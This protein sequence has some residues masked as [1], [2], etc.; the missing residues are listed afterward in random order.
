MNGLTLAVLSP[1]LSSIATIFYG[2]AVRLLNPFVALTFESFIGAIFIFLI[3]IARRQKIDFSKI[4]T[5][6]KDLILLILTRGIIGNLLITFG[7]T[8]STGIKAIF[9]TKAEPYF[10]IFWFWIFTREKIEKKHLFLLFIHILGAI[11]LSSGSLGFSFN[12]GQIGDFLIIAAVV[13][14]ALSYFPASKVVNHLG[15]LQTNAIT[16]F[17][18]GFVFLPFALLYYDPSGWSSHIGWIYLVVAAFTFNVLALTFWFASLK[19]IKGWMVSAL[20]ALGPLVGAPFAI[21]F[22]GESLTPIQIAGGAVVLATSFLI[23][24]E[25]F[26]K[27]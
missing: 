10:V 4:K 8:L 19:T 2:E 17:I 27:K 21:I 12:S 14:Y 16:L 3:L 18:S 20:R 6:K 9:F 23:A 24:R 7:L 15:A 22:F 13:F 26:K 11:L 1:F 25:H 5:H